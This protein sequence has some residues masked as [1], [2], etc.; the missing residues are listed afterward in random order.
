MS[1][2]MVVYQ[3]V[4]EPNAHGEGPHWDCEEQALYFVDIAG[5]AVHRYHAESSTHTFLQ[6]NDS[7][8]V[9]IPIKGERSKFA[10]GYGRDISVLTW[11]WKTG[12][13]SLVKRFSVENDKPNN[14]FNDGKADTEGRLWIGTMSVKQPAPGEGSLY[15]VSSDC[16]L[17]KQFNDISISNGITWSLDEKLMYYIDSPTRRI[18]VFDYNIKTGAASGR[19]KFF[20]FEENN[21]RGVPDGMT[22]DR[23]GNLWVACWNGS[24]VI[25]IS[26]A[27]I[28][29]SHVELPTDLVTSV[30]WG[31]R[32]LS[33]LYVTT[34]YIELDPELRKKQ[35]LAGATFAVTGLATA[36][37]SGGQ[38]VSPC[39]LNNNNDN[40]F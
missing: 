29:M 10:L 21:V 31:G 7:V 28:L 13:Y 26:S 30:A 18:D 35:P 2:K 23:D 16:K 17:S 1:S 36:G 34:M 8:N 12:K 39:F 19:R 37:H 33:T 20:A 6:L 24:Q 15:R 14:R 3:A 9:V 22:I 11:D 27:G 5:K 4:V 40:D 32:D 25:Q 38:E